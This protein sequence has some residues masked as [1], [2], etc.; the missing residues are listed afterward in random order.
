MTRVDDA[1]E[2][3][4]KPLSKRVKINNEVSLLVCPFG[5]KWNKYQ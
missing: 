1:S 3:E 2:D 5:G 4:E